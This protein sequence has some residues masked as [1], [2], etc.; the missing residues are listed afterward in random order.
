[1]PFIASWPAEIPKGLEVDATAMNIDFFPTFLKMAGIPLPKDREIDGVD[2]LPL[3]KGE[4]TDALH[5]ELYFIDGQ[6]VMG[7]RTRDNFKFVDRH[8][9]ENS[10]YFMSKQGPFLFDLNHDLNESYNADT[11]YPE[12][13]DALRERLE[14]KREDMKRNPR[15]WKDHNRH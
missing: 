2:M 1:V 6:K 10:T 3:L 7:L 11:H 14:I 12:K 5:E 9:S 13:M 4:A 8:R 15:G